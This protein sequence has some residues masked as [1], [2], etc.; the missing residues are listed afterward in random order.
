M[1]LSG[2]NILGGLMEMESET[3]ESC[4]HLFQLWVM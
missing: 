3:V 2:K 4:N 1:L